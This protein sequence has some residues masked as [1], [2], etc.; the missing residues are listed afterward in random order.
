MWQSH[1]W[2]LEQSV[3]GEAERHIFDS[4]GGAEVRKRNFTSLE[5]P[6]KMKCR[7]GPSHR[8]TSWWNKYGSG[9]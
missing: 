6:A 3:S 2:Q 5:V 4:Q 7:S 8:L 9:T 1:F